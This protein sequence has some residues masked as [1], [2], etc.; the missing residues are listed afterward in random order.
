MTMG[1]F[2]YITLAFLFGGVML[3]SL[4]LGGHDASVDHDVSH[5]GHAEGGGGWQ[6]WFSIKVLSAFG[7]AFGASGAISSIH[8]NTAAWSIPIALGSGF[9]CGFVVKTL[10]GF[11]GNQEGN[12][13]YSRT[14]LA[15]QEGTIIMGILE[16]DEIGEAQFIVDGQI[17]NFPAKSSDGKSISQGE[18]IVVETVGSVLVVKRPS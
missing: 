1:T 9:V 5:G 12:A 16:G 10:I 17:V 13:T 2:I 7:T 11:L 15:G 14:D 6:A 18:K 4:L 3:I 8:A